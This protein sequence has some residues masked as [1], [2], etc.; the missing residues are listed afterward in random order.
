MLFINSFS[1][2]IILFFECY[3]KIIVLPFRSYFKTNIIEEKDILDNFFPKKI[4]TEVLIGDPPQCLNINLNSESFAFQISPY[5]CDQNFTSYYNHNKSKSFNLIFN[6]YIDEG[7]ELYEGSYVSDFFSFY[8]STDLRTNIS[9]NGFEF[10]YSYY[11]NKEYNT[12][13]LVGLG[14]KERFS[15]YNGNTFIYSLK[16][17]NLINNSFWTYAYF[18]KDIKN[19]K[20]LQKGKRI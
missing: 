20:I 11:T 19:N 14:F 12:C 17:N 10:I 8:N 18:D 3:T 4:Y 16:K 5:E 13:A 2:L 15:E 7:F 6:E 9:K 1:I